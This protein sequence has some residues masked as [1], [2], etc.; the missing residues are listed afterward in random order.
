MI[1]G[2]IFATLFHS[3]Q[4]PLTLSINLENR[5]IPISKS[6][7]GVFFEEINRAGDGGLYGE[8][9][10]NR[11]FEKAGKDGSAPDWK[12]VRGTA[13]LDEMAAFNRTHGHSL[14]ITGTVANSG[15]WG[16][17][18]KKGE[19]YK[20]IVWVKGNGKFSAALAGQSLDLGE[21]TP[22]WNKIEV[23]L[24]AKETST[25]GQL[26]FT[27][28]GGTAW[29]GFASLMSQ[30]TV[31]KAPARADLANL[32][33]GMS[34]SFVR[35]PGGCFV[36]GQDFSRMWNWRDSIGSIEGRKGKALGF[37]GYSSTN[38]LGFHEYLQWCEDMKSDG[39]FVVNCGMT[40]GPY[41]PMAEMPEVAQSALDAIEYANGP[42]T[43]EYG[44]R[45]AQ[46]GHPK[47]FNIKYIEI[48][49]E[50]GGPIYDE[51]Y[52]FM[53]K[54]IKAKYPEMKLVACVW[55]G[56]PKSYP[57]EIIDEHYY[58]DPSFFW[59]QIH[60][61]DSYNRKGP[62]IYVGE[63]AVTQ[64]CGLG[65][66]DAAL[67]EAAFMTGMERNSDVV[68]MSSY[69]PLFVNVN[70]KQ[71]NPNAIV[72]NNHQSYGTPSYWVQRLFAQHRP[73]EL[74]KTQTEESFSEPKVVGPVGIQ[75]WKTSA[76]FKDISVEIDGKSSDLHQWDARSGVWNLDQPVISQSDL[77]QDM[78]SFARG[79][80]LAGAKDV[81]YRLKAR[82]IAG[83]EGFIIMLGGRDGFHVQWNLG[84]WGNKEHA[85]QI[86]GGAGVNPVKGRIETDRWYD[87]RVELHGSRAEGYLD[88][89]LVSS[90]QLP[91]A[92]D[93][94]QIVGYDTKKREVV[95]KL[96]NGR[97]ESRGIKLDFAKSRIAGAAKAWVLTGPSL[98]AENDF[99]APNRIAPVEK[100]VV[101]GSEPVYTMPPLS[102][103]ILRVKLK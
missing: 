6:L 50:N 64:G 103:S 65:N 99:S 71:W 86:S 67:A 20:L 5:G 18:Q 43:S 49:N 94:A 52:A 96:V 9:L 97:A 74:I 85:F 57:L 70:E 60:K 15:F 79:I 10:Q 84:G 1:T 37:W 39:L 83:D 62:Q 14:K 47:P 24:T 38:G 76:E 25:S 42:V 40:H 89:T 30:K 100:T 73:D 75:T 41:T 23:K 56:T 78:V 8:L 54:A 21:L 31:G 48:G 69:A 11:G 4:T 55:G 66:L 98:A 7:Y 28:T 59:S 72:F 53:A 3:A 93:F 22:G 63:Y 102:L 80:N 33:A 27:V 68:K 81:V 91:K 2:L 82:K 19:T 51:R 95:I 34:P 46:N 101:L 58:S 61:Y 26:E 92:Y 90:I 35:F 88:G 12:A 36:E 87:I 32:V 77:G 29:I 13:S 45:R 17:P 44:A 16:I